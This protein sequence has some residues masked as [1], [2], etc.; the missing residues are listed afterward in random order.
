MNENTDKIEMVKQLYN[1]F[2]KKDIPAIL[3][4]L[5]EDIE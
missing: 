4:L 3:R 2:L 5:S 1:A